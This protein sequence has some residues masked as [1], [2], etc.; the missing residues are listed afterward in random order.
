MLNFR[1]NRALVVAGSL[2]PAVCTQ[3]DGR[4]ATEKA[5]ATVNPH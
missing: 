3:F 1:C 2:Q 5:V 4:C